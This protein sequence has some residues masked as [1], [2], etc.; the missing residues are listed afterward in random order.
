MLT[1][2]K[3][4]NKPLPELI[5]ERLEGLIVS[6]EFKPGD[7]LPSEYM[8]AQRLGVGRSTVREA[9]KSLVSQNILEIRRG[10]G[11]FVCEQTGIVDDP[12]GLRFLSNKKQL[13]IDLCQVRLMIEPEIVAIAAKKATPEEIDQMQSLCNQIADKV[14]QDQDY[15]RLDQKLHTLWASCTRNTIMPSLIPVLD[16]AIPLFIDITKRS[17]RYQSIKTHQAIVDAIRQRDPDAARKAMQQ[18]LE[19][20]LR[21]IESLPDDD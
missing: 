10:N 6:G 1:E 9:I 2:I 18:H 17:L 19:D 16:Q 12:L 8:L 13:G 5:S 11:T 4:T 7:K 21:G 15:D 14:Y 3:A 20:N